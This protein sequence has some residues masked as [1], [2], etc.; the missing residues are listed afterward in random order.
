MSRAGEMLRGAGV[1]ATRKRKL[2]LAAVLA[3]PVALPPGALLDDA[4]IAGAMDRATLYR[5]LDVLVAAGLVLRTLGPDRSYHYCAG[6]GEPQGAEHSHFYC[7]RCGAMRCLPRG[8]LAIDRG[9]L[10]DAAAVGHVEIRLD[11]VCGPCRGA[12]K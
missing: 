6:S 11:G 3:A 12:G 8:A 10:P 4:D 7:L 1:R 5:T 2:V 9:K